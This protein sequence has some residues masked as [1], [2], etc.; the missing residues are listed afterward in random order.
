MVVEDK[1]SDD[2]DARFIWS[3]SSKEWI[4]NES[5]YKCAGCLKHYR[6][7]ASLQVHVEQGWRQGFS[8][9]VFYR[10]LKDMWENSIQNESQKSVREQTPESMNSYQGKKSRK[11]K[12][13]EEEEPGPKRRRLV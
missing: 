1:E 3:H 11:R 12:A 4:E 10:K 2:L 5:Q 9:R 13:A 6:S 8:C 7:L